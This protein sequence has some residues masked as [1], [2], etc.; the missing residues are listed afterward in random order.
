MVRIRDFQS[1]DVGSIPAGDTK[2]NH[3]S[4]MSGRIKKRLV[5]EC[6]TCGKGFEVIPS[7]KNLYMRCRECIDAGHRTTTKGYELSNRVV[8][9]CVVCGGPN[10]RTEARIK[11][12][13]R[14]DA[15][16]RAGRSI[17]KGKRQY[18]LR[19]EPKVHCPWFN[20]TIE[21]PA[22]QVYIL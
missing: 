9:P 1:R 3:K 20:G 6:I 7:K 14:C 4:K 22:A 10:R 11:R 12:Y 5:K 17:P 8:K 15:C 19:E 18:T 16:V 21:G 13:K 2:P